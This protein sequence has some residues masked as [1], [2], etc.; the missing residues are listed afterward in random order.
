M[1][2]LNYLIFF[3]FFITLNFSANSKILIK[4]KVDDEIITNIDIIDEKNYLL[5]IRPN[6][7]KLSDKEITKISENSI[8]Q[9][10]IKKKELK[11]IFKND[12]N[13]K[14]IN[15]IKK[16]LFKFKN[17]KTEQEFAELSKKNN[18]NYNKI[19]NKIKYEAMWNEL[20]FQKYSSL[21]KVNEDKLR[22]DLKS[23]FAE[24][25]KYEY[26]LSEMLFE[27]DKLESFEIKYEEILKYIKNNDFKTAAA[28][29]SISKSSYNGGEIGWI[30]DTLLSKKL[31]STLE[32][33]SI[34]EISKPIKYPNGYLIL[35][36]NNKREIKQF[37]SLNKELRELINFEKNRQLSQF[38]LLFY[39]K[40]KQNTSINEY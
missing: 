12:Q 32:K 21:V 24:N 19:I 13:L 37:G 40:L 25:R 38:S 28:K 39:K 15:E 5:F 8:I 31:R 22:E 27:I 34:N 35:K 4:Y 2:K 6:L 14:F 1:K 18:V 7:K 29:F 10:I 9:E 23:K 3:L 30:K 26:D 11:K 33:L 16:S 17:V 36:I 20:I